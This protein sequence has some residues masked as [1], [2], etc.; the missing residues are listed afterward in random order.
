MEATPKNIAASGSP[1]RTG[2]IARKIGTAPR[3]PTHEMNVIS[4]AVYRN[5]SKHSATAIGRAT[6]MSTAAIATEGASIGTKALGVTSRPSMRK[7]TIWL[8]QAKASNAWLM[9]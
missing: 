6:S 1:A 8:S 3:K 5:G 4:G 7:R 2:M 9:T